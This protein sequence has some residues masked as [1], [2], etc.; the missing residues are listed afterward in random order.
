VLSA[1]WVLV[2]NQS[3]KEVQL[4]KISHL[5]FMVRRHVLQQQQQQQQQQAAAAAGAAAAAAAAALPVVAVPAPGPGPAKPAGKSVT[6]LPPPA[7]L[8]SEQRSTAVGMQRQKSS[9]TLRA[10]LSAAQ[11]SPSTPSGRSWSAKFRSLPSVKVREVYRSM[12]GGSSSKGSVLGGAAGAEPPGDEFVAELASLLAELRLERKLGAMQAWCEDEEIEA[13]TELAR[14][15]KKKAFA[16]ALIAAL[17]LKPGK[18][19]AVNLLD[20]I[21]ERAA[22]RPAQQMSGRI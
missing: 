20:L 19:K 13:M 11:L 14:I 17:E 6:L 10:L 3:D 2:T 5:D 16:D 22:K 15:V 12:V 4:Y 18:A 9:N 1:P 21:A 7:P 8:T